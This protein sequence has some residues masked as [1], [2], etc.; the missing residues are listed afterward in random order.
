VLTRTLQQFT[1]DL[2]DAQLKA[3]GFN[4]SQI[5][6]I[7]T[8]AKTARQ[9]ATQVKTVGQLFDVMKESIASG[10]AQSFKIVIGNFDEARKSLTAVSNVFSDIIGR[11]AET[12]NKLLSDWKKL[13][14]RA[15][16][17][18]GIRIAF[19]DLKRALKPIHD[20]FREIFPART[21]RDLFNMTRSFTRLM[22]ELR[23]SDRTMRDL[24][25]TFA[26]FFATLHIGWN[27]IKGVV[28]VFENLLRP[29]TKNARSILD[30]TANIGDFLVHLDRVLIKGGALNRFFERLTAR[31]KEPLQQLGRV[32]AAIGSLFGVG[33]AR[34]LDSVTSS[35]DNFNKKLSPFAK[36][37]DLARRA[38]DGFTRIIDKV[39]GAIGPLL[40]EIG[41]TI[42]NFG[43][44]VADSIRHANYNAVFAAVNTVLLGGIFLAIKKFMGGGLKVDVGGGLLKNIS[45]LFSTLTGNLKSMQRNVQAKTLLAIAAALAVLAVA[46]I[47][48]STINPRKLASAMTAVAVGMAELVSSMALLNKAAGGSAFVRMPFIA[49]S[50]ILLAGA[51]ILMAGAAKIFATMSWEQISKG[52]TAVAGMLAAVS[53]ATQ[54]ANPARMLATGAAMLP[55]ALGIAILAGAAKLFATMSWRDISKGLAGIGGLLL[56]IGIAM[57]AFPPTAALMGPSLVLIAIAIDTLAGAVAAFGAMDQRAV[58]QGVLAIAG[59]LVAIGLAIDTIPPTLAL[60]AAGLLILAAALAGIS[61]VVLAFGHMSPRTLA[62][63]IIAMGA[64][65]V[66][67]AVGLTAMDGTL[68]GSLALL[69]AAAAFTMLAPAVALMGQLS[70]GTLVHGLAAMAAIL[71]VLAIA[72]LIAGPALVALGVGLLAIGAGVALVGAGVFLFAKGLSLLSDTAVKAFAALLAAGALFIAAFPGMVINFVKGIIVILNQLT[73]LAP[74]IVSSLVVIIG[75]LLDGL[76]KLAPKAAEAITVL[77][78]QILKVLNDNSE[79]I[80]TAGYDLL[81]KLLQGLADNI[82]PVTD[83][84]SDIIVNFLNALSANLPRIIAAGLHLLTSFLTGII[85]G[86]P[87][88]AA[89][90]SH[91][92]VVFLANVTKHIPEIVVAAGTLIA[93]FITSIASQIP[94]IVAAGVS[95]ITNFLTGIQQAIPRIVN[96]ALDVATTFINSIARGLLRLINV[97]FNAMVNFM[98][99]LANAI[100]KNEP[101]VIAAGYN[102][103]TAIG[104]GMVQ[105][106]KDIAPKL[107]HRVGK[108]ATDMLDKVTSVFDM[109]SPS[110]VFLG[111]GKNV[112]IG[113]A[114]GLDDHAPRVNAS[115]TAAATNAVKTAKN[116]FAMMPNV[117]E[118]IDSNPTITPVLDLSLV[119]KQ[120]PHLANMMPS[121]S[122]DV[123]M[124]SRDAASSI[125]MQQK[126]LRDVP[127]SQATTVHFEQNNYSPEP[128]SSIE[129]Y[130]QT[131]NQIS[132]VKSL[133]KQ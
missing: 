42:A 58:A 4:D 79:P 89:I 95:I 119:K 96:K 113:L 34:G 19:D 103:A 132:R 68:P 84:V 33:N 80:I 47:V 69:A 88:I 52:L 94:K 35:L 101:R 115:I 87:R 31:L 126:K 39:K 43:R 102:I 99:G 61:G 26:G 85:G 57:N 25:R 59:A 91:M 76:I 128:L 21:G 13:G 70:W 117:L 14:G 12:R 64:A 46:M 104:D 123:G 73:K 1:G 54:L 9:A 107:I 108:I 97:A 55:V 28:G 32:A 122:I 44:I 37:V 18:K 67:L 51:M 16:L 111:I 29:V 83:K 125:A 60:Q 130:R 75:Q 129:I 72:G 53:V 71:G 105:G 8:Q 7:Q 81:N 82:G 6:A 40:R 15:E 5:Q 78:T 116:Q 50:L 10:W 114:N 45:A 90:V 3:Q 23:P 127:V 38:W 124:T 93:N 56:G 49:G 100:R 110:K 112:M 131:N 106:L 133:V 27:I 121:S 118:H 22:R 98:N 120:A 86:I 2:T 17:I 63:G 74:K 11:S 30:F 41:D 92:I 48:L 24:R 77:I 62:R 109:G 66:V 20:A 65:L 36:F